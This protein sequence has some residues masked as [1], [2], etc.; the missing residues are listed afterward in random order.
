MLHNNVHKETSRV[1]APVLAFFAGYWTGLSVKMAVTP[2]RR[3]NFCP[4]YTLEDR[5]SRPPA[6]TVWIIAHVQP[7]K[8]ESATRYSM[9]VAPS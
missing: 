9:Y 4:L 7:C 3:G 1:A 8:D 2:P 5:D 6:A